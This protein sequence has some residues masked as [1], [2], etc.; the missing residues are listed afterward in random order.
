[1]SECLNEK[2][3][4]S[5]WSSTIRPAA[6]ASSSE[7][8][9]SSSSCSRST[10][11]SVL[12]RKSVPS[13]AASVSDLERLGREPIEAPADHLLDARRH[14][15]AGILGRRAQELLDEER[16]AAGLAAEALHRRPVQ[17]VATD[18][19][20]HELGRLGSTQAAEVD[21][22]EGGLAPQ[23]GEQAR[24]R[25][26]RVG[27]HV[28]VGGD[29]QQRRSGAAAQDLAQQQHGGDVG[30]VQVL[31]HQ[32]QPVPVG[33]VEQQP[34]HR[35]EELVAEPLV[36]VA[37]RGRGGRTGRAELGDQARQR[38][39]AG[40]RQPDLL[41]QARTVRGVV[42]QRLD[43]RLV[44]RH[45]L[46]VAAPVQDDGAVA[47]HRGGESRH[48]AR[49]A[50]AG[51]AGAHHQA[52]LVARGLVPARLQPPQRGGAAYERSLL[53]PREDAGHRD[54]A[55][56]RGEGTHRDGRR[57]RID[58]RTVSTRSSPGGQVPRRDCAARC[59]PSS[60]CR[61]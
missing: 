47:V 31:E 49:L 5:S 19:G 34:D 45:A 33:G 27:V 56:R 48:Q 61:C 20:G 23:V 40:L 46:L 30:P 2:R 22:V 60:R 15:G 9:S 57:S 16:V 6:T 44:R 39:G 32:Q 58:L 17:R 18:A 50:D 55:E 54:L 13:A 38:L 37:A 14:A 1:M 3:S 26:A 4:T 52:A 8:I 53:G 11:R 36:L 7:T 51:L 21:L 43:E 29:H 42:P 59:S 28:A 10:A 25:P 35:L 24:H 12:S 41:G